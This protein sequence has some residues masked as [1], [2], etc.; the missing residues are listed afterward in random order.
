MEK[1]DVQTSSSTIWSAPSSIDD[2]SPMHGDQGAQIN[3]NEIFE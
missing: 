1:L 3:V 2:A